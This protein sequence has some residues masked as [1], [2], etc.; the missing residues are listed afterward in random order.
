MMRETKELLTMMVATG[1]PL[2]ASRIHDVSIAK[3]CLLSSRL[4]F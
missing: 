3:H 4:G 1:T 2:Y